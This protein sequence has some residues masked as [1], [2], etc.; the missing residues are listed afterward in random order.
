MCVC[1]CVCVRARRRFCEWE[2]VCVSVCVGFTLLC[3]CSNIFAADY[4]LSDCCGLVVRL[5]LG[6]SAARRFGLSGQAKYFF[7][8]FKGTS[9]TK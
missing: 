5:S 6:L 9:K 2:G 4:S 8:P 3:M 7:I 1:V